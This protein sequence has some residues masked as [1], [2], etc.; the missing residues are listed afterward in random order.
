MTT[1]LALLALLAA[2]PQAG[3][4]ADGDL[5]AL[6]SEMGG[7]RSQV[8]AL[9]AELR[10]R[11][12]AFEGLRREFASMSE[13]LVALKDRPQVSVAGPFLSAPPASS[14]TAGVARV[15]VFAPRLN[16]DAA[17]RHDSLSLRLRRLDPGSARVVA[18]LELLADQSS[19]EIPLDQ[20]GALY[21]LEWQTSEGH[22]YALAL[23]D[24]ASGLPVATV[25][26][27]PQQT[28]GRFLFV[29]Y[30]VE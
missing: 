27:R 14:D 26:V 15:A 10:A 13:D 25:Q 29:G 11:A 12:E 1:G 28:K 9:H 22:A 30:R 18:D 2:S 5:A 7:L 16:I 6:H 24:G 3:G 23:Q 21:V 8:A 4:R 19:L 17:R 20:N